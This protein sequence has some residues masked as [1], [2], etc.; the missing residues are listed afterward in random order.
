MVGIT[1]SDDLTARSSGP[2]ED[3]LKYANRLIAAGIVPV[4]ITPSSSAGVLRRLDGLLVPGGP[5][6]APERYGE[7]A[8]GKLGGTEP[9]L[10]SLELEQVADARDRRLP[11]L[12]ICRGQQLINVALG[13]TLHQHVTHPQWGDDPAQPV[14]DV[15]ITAG[16][17]LHRILG[18]ATARVNSG[19]HQAVAVV[20]PSLIACAYSDDGHVEAV[21]SGE[22]RIVAVQ[23]HPEEMPATELT[24]RLFAAF[25]AWVN[26]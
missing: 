19:H 13:G 20:A 17:Q 15:R 21:E 3:P 14:H 1:W 10:D 4:F 16:T 7:T 8:S 23:W 26:G 2:G 11:I 6:I 9:D 5:D 22:H 25:A 12:G 24:G 18:V